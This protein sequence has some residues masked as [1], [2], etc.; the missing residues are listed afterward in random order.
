M[1][2]YTYKLLL[3][4]KVYEIPMMFKHI[5]E[6]PHK[7]TKALIFNQSHQYQVE[8]NV[9]DDIFQSFIDYMINDELP[10]IN[11]SNIN[12]FLQLSQEFGLLEDDLK[13]KIA[14]LGEY[15]V[16]LNGLHNTNS[17]DVSFYEEQIAIKL[18]DYLLKYGQILMDSSIQSLFNIFNHKKRKMTKN[19]LAYEL[20]IDCFERKNNPDIFILLESIDGSK[21]SKSHLENAIKFKEKR[22]NHMPTIQFSYLASAI[23][24]QDKLQSQIDALKAELIQVKN[25]HEIDIKNLIKKNEND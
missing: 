7:I 17:S 18:D 22:F 20:I 11:I 16:N 12:D 8:S 9:N 21:L 13:T 1:Q 4:N 14:Q 19:D 6:I 25:Q 24:S 23:E 3:K 15:L 10:D 2:N 5:V